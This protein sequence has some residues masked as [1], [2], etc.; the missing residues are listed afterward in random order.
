[1]ISCALMSVYL[2]VIVDGFDVAIMSKELIQLRANVER[3]Y[4]LDLYCGAGG[5]AKGY[6]DAG[7]EVIGVDHRPQPRYP[8]Q[9]IQ[10]DAKQFLLDYDLS[11]FSAIHASP[12]CQQYSVCNFFLQRDYPDDI[13]EIRFLLLQTELPY[14]IENVP[15]AP[16]NDPIMLCG[17]MFGLGV[18]RH[19]SFESNVSLTVPHHPM[20]HKQDG[21][22]GT[23]E[24]VAGNLYSVRSGRKAMGINWMIK[25]ELSQ[26]IPP[27]YT[28]YIGIQLLEY[29]CRRDNFENQPGVNVE[30][31]QPVGFV[32]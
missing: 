13:R 12:P 30:Q 17:T 4:L 29:I 27:V 7:F 11:L 2:D 21:M 5:C 18:I 20:H 3:K 19:R 25:S 32:V 28:E 8:Y 24:T 10:Y 15:L 16:L 26:A 9:F 31:I 1:M 23:F 14:V 6:A 22:T